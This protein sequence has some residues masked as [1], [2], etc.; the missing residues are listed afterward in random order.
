MGLEAIHH[1]DTYVPILS[2]IE[3]HHEW[4]IAVDVVIDSLAPLGSEYTMALREG[5]RGRWCDRYP[6]EGKQSG[7]P[8]RP[9]PGC[10]PRSATW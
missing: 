4:D 6:N 3:K 7:A 9:T 10:A 5:L 8:D 1:Y 2:D